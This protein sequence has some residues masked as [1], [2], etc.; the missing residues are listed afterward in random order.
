MKPASV[1]AL[2]SDPAI[3]IKDAIALDAAGREVMPRWGT[4]VRWSMYGA[5]LYVYALPHRYG[6]EDEDSRPAQAA[7]ERMGKHLG[8]HKRNVWAWGDAPER[9]HA[10]VMEALTAASV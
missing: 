3:W 2:L 5:I 8:I 6:H 7:L 4:G 9:T 1:A 10:E